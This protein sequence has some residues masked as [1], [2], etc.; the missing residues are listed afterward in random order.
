MNRVTRLWGGLSCHMACAW[1]YLLLMPT[2]PPMNDGEPFLAKLEAA[3]EA[4]DADFVEHNLPRLEQLIA[5]YQD[6]ICE[7]A[8]LQ[9]RVREI[10]DR[11]EPSA[12]RRLGRK[13]D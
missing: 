1:C 4:G 7:L 13:G 12:K 5:Q 8:K 6:R 11:H 3:I 9:C 10:C 2:K